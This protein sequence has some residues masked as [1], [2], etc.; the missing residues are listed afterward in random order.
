MED[1]GHIIPE[2]VNRPELFPDAIPYFSAFSE[3]TTSR[4]SGFAVGHILYSEIISYLNEHQIF[5][6]EDREEYIKW[7]Q[8]IDG[9]YVANSN[10]K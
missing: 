1:E 7:I 6:T 3:L 4:Q 9:L 5:N 8:F 10:K 2:L